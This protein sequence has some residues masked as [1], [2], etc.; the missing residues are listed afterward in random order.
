MSALVH[1]FDTLAEAEQ[2]AAENP[3]TV[4]R[5][6]DGDDVRYEAGW[7]VQEPGARYWRRGKPTF[8]LL[9]PARA[10]FERLTG[11]QT[12]PRYDRVLRARPDFVAPDGMSARLHQGLHRDRELAAVVRKFLDHLDATLRWAC[13]PEMSERERHGLAA[14]RMIWGEDPSDW[15]LLTPERREMYC[16]MAYVALDAHLAKQAE[17]FSKLKE[18]V[19]TPGPATTVGS[20]AETSPLYR[21]AREAVLKGPTLEQR[22]RAVVPVEMGVVGRDSDGRIYVIN[23]YGNWAMGGGFEL[24]GEIIVPDIDHPATQ[25]VMMAEIRKVFPS[26]FCCYDRDDG[27]WLLSLDAFTDCRAPTLGEAL[28]RGLEHIA[29]AGE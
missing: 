24:A 4:F 16:R 17:L 25:G 10:T 8:P 20:M 15:R 13:E 2:Y 21:A 12:G 6:H 27:D 22:I 3:G 1:R 5:D 7:H 29:E 9:V 18:T 28:L 26:G 11:F 14:Y 23:G 19:A